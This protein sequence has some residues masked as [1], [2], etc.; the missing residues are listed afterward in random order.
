MEY[1]GAVIIFMLFTAVIYF[2]NFHT[3]EDDDDVY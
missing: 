2:D 3:D 1:F